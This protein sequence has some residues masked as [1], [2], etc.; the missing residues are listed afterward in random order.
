MVEHS[1]SV[2]SKNG[3][4]PLGKKTL[5]FKLFIF[6]RRTDWYLSALIPFGVV[7]RGVMQVPCP[8]GASWPPVPAPAPSHHGTAAVSQQRKAQ[9][10][11]SFRAT[12]TDRP[13]SGSSCQL[14][15]AAAA[16]RLH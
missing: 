12:L 16:H 5:E 10:V 8:H 1:V 11:G 2:C 6:S 13:S 15:H 14:A 4:E 3:K 7:N 9:I